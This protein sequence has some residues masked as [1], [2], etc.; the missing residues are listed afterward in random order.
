MKSLFKIISLVLVGCLHFSCSSEIIEAPSTE[1]N[2]NK[3]VTA[4]AL[5]PKEPATRVVI[6]DQSTGPSDFSTE[7]LSFSW[8]SNDMLYA[9]DASYEGEEQPHLYEFRC[10]NPETGSFSCLEAIPD[11]MQLNFIARINWFGPLDWWNGSYSHPLL[12][13]WAHGCDS[14]SILSEMR[15]RIQLQAVGTIVNGNVNLQFNHS[16]SFVRV[17]VDGQ[18]ASKGYQIKDL[19]VN[20]GVCQHKLYNVI[21][22]GAFLF[23]VPGSNDELQVKATF[24]NIQTGIEESY[25]FNSETLL[26]AGKVYW[27]QPDP[28][29][30]KWERDY[31]ITLPNVF[32]YDHTFEGQPDGGTWGEIYNGDYILLSGDKQVVLN[33]DQTNRW[34]RE[35][36]VD[37]P[38][39]LVYPYAGSN[40]FLNAGEIGN[41][42]VASEQNGDEYPTHFTAIVKSWG[43]DFTGDNIQ[44]VTAKIVG[45]QSGTSIPAKYTIES[46]DGTPLSG[47]FSVSFDENDKVQIA[48]VQNGAASVS[49]SQQLMNFGLEILPG[50]YAQ[51]ITIKARYIDING[52]EQET[53]VY[54]SGAFTLNCGELFEFPPFVIQ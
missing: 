27:V 14:N 12:D 22:D 7:G 13:V 1:I 50:T 25:V 18:L 41:F 15:S 4:I 8:E 38:L 26:E 28:A 52:E 5:L 42:V 19:F 34:N 24:L 46:N 2:K 48:S 9:W 43:F 49:T 40:L 31:T 30:S 20:S 45:Y 29:N 21:G 33:S 51:G 37:G 23:S 54:R 53:V 3:G 6:T 35:E 16:N 10:S 32:S 17:F 11:G 36:K 47:T 39:F 44:T